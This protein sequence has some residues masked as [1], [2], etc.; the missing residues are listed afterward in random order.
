[1]EACKSIEMHQNR[2]ACFLIY[3]FNLQKFTRAAAAAVHFKGPL[4]SNKTKVRRE[5]SCW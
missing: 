3:I 1:M 5:K 4:L 2:D